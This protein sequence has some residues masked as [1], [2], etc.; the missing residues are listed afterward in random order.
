MGANTHRSRAANR[1]TRKERQ[2]GGQK[3]SPGL[4]VSFRWVP[5]HHTARSEATGP[6][7]IR[8][9]IL[10]E[11]ED[12]QLAHSFGVTGCPVNF[13]FTGSFYKTE[14]PFGFFSS[15][16][17]ILNLLLPPPPTILLPF[18]PFLLLSASGF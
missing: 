14:F 11:A 18:L 1:K 17:P 12:S 4:G 16:T 2:K 3:R 5:A 7:T 8:R 6:T 13:F 9:P 15:F 10:A